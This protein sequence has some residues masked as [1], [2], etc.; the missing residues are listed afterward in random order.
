MRMLVCVAMAVVGFFVGW[1]VIAACALAIG[2]LAGV[3][4][5]E[6]A[7]AMGAVFQIG[8]IGG[9][10]GA[11]IGGW[12]GWRRANR[13]ARVRITDADYFED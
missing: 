12:L 1:V 8:P 6:G 11:C 9:L 4:Q 3:S 5:F 10:V 7:F 2:E 13:R